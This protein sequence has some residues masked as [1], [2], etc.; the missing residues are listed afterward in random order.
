MTITEDDLYIGKSHL[1][2]LDSLS[3]HGV[4]TLQS[5][6]KYFPATLPCP[7]LQ[8]GGETFSSILTKIAFFL[9]SPSNTN[10]ISNKPLIRS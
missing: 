3:S 10:L 5:Q 6:N 4:T 8:G 1:V 7:A 2:P 9:Q